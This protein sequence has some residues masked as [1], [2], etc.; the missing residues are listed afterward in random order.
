MTFN[1]TSPRSFFSGL[2]EPSNSL[3]L[4]L[5][6][7]NSLGTIGQIYQSVIT[8]QPIRSGSYFAVGSQKDAIKPKLGRMISTIRLVAAVNPLVLSF[9]SAT[10][11][12]SSAVGIRIRSDEMLVDLRLSQRQI[13]HNTKGHK[14]VLNRKSVS[15]WNLEESRVDFANLEMMT[16]SC[17]F[18]GDNDEYLKTTGD[19]DADNEWFIESD[20]NYETDSSKMKLYPFIT[21]PKLTYYRRTEDFRKAVDQESKKKIGRPAYYGTFGFD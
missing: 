5:L 12:V 21:A 19:S 18:A 20:F 15:K 1:I 10:E 4:T 8:N 14:N 6:N 11:L 2:S 16:L 13:T 7:L 17:G 3:N 9:L